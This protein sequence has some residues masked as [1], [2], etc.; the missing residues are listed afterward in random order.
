MEAKKVRS[1]ISPSSIA[2]GATF[3]TQGEGFG[4]TALLC[5]ASKSAQYLNFTN[6][7]KKPSPWV[8]KV[9]PQ[10]T[11]E[12]ETG[13]RST[14]RYASPCV[15][16]P[17]GRGRYMVPLSNGDP[18]CWRPAWGGVR[19]RGAVW[20]CRSPLHPVCRYDEVICSEMTRGLQGRGTIYVWCKI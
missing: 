11:D 17:V 2:C 16:V 7:R 20:L 10:A 3:P 6:R 4:D 12:G 1:P 19:L 5:T 15:R 8:G 14:K 18:A 13:E 9:A